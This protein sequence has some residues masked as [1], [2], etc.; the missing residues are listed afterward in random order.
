[1][2][3]PE[4][5]FTHTVWTSYT[6]SSRLENHAVGTSSFRF[7]CVNAHLVCVVGWTPST[8][9]VAWRG[10]RGAAGTNRLVF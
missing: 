9:V 3:L 7:R 1:M 4:T 8:V 6:V 5:A 10:C 2:L